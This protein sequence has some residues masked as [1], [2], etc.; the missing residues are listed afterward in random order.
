[1]Q[2]KYVVSIVA[3]AGWRYL[4]IRIQNAGS[5]TVYWQATGIR[6]DQPRYLV[7]QAR[8][9]VLAAL[10]EEA[11]CEAQCEAWGVDYALRQQPPSAWLAHWLESKRET[12]CELSL[13]HI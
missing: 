2:N 10:Y 9:R 13:I 8:R 5:R 6:A 1:M 12:V 4:I 7:E 3:K 11:R